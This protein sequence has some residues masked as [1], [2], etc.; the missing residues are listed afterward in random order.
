MK[1]SKDTYKAGSE[2][3][4]SMNIT[5]DD[6]N[7]LIRDYGI[8]KGHAN[9]QTRKRLAIILA[10]FM[11]KK[12]MSAQDSA[13]MERVFYNDLAG[14]DIISGITDYEDFLSNFK[15][16]HGIEPLRIGLPE[17]VAYNE[18]IRLKAVQI[19]TYIEGRIKDE[20]G[21]STNRGNTMSGIRGKQDSVS[22]IKAKG[23]KIHSRIQ[24][25]TLL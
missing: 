8:I 24:N 12:G 2:K 1:N 18:E 14:V 6:L 20:A 11:I 25:Q 19:I 21:K 7:G 10:D 15:G 17:G 23:I 16:C 3:E 22:G 4:A 9:E 13:I 5:K